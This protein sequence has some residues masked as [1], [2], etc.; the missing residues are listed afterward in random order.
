MTESEYMENLENDEESKGSETKKAKSVVESLMK[1]VDKAKIDLEQTP[2][3]EDEDLKP[4]FY[5]SNQRLPT[6]D[7]KYSTR[8]KQ[9]S[10]QS[11]M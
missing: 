9:D 7:R 8:S 10:K 4:F 5:R 6:V 1:S 11:L 3:L 2:I